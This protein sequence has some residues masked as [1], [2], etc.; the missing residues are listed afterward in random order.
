MNTSPVPAATEP[1]PAPY[2]TTTRPYRQSV[3]ERL[4]LPPSDE[5]LA[6]LGRLDVHFLGARGQV[7]AGKAGVEYLVQR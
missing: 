7:N 6:F 3:A 4:Y 5:E 2:P 1:L